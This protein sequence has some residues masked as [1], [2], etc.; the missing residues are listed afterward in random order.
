METRHEKIEGRG[1]VSV[2]RRPRPCP[3]AKLTRARSVNHVVKS[4]LSSREGKLRRIG[5]RTSTSYIYYKKVG[6]GTDR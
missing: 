4:N 3:E 1:P 2:L 5:R 6:G